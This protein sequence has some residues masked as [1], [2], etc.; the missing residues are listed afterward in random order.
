MLRDGLL[1]A[2]RGG[3]DAAADLLSDSSPWDWWAGTGAIWRGDFA[4]DL[5]RLQEAEGWYLAAWWHPV[6]HERLGMLYQQMGRP[7]DAVD[8][9]ERFV[10]G[11]EDAD[12]PLQRRVEAARER[13]AALT[14]G[15]A[16]HGE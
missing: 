16:E 3:L 15:E 1:R 9:Y 10:R 5:G 4:R 13:L 8:A 12:A 14:A 7:E 11:W 6:A 2:G